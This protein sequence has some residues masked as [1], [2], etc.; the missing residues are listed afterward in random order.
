[1]NEP[2]QKFQTKSLF[3]AVLVALAFASSACSRSNSD[4]TPTPAELSLD[5]SSGDD[6]PAEDPTIEIVPTRSGTLALTL[7][8]VT[9]ETTIESC[10][11][12]PDQI[13]V[14]ALGT[15]DGE[16]HKVQ[17]GAFTAD[18]LVLNI[19]PKDLLDP[20]DETWIGTPNLELSETR[21]TATGVEMTNTSGDTATAD[22]EVDCPPA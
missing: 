7:N 22:L 21:A 5:E 13:D 10:T 15:R 6:A 14:L 9:Y 18:Q 4:E 19:N 1:M 2:N 17:L 8:N 12:S 16:P 20:G 11:L 3:L